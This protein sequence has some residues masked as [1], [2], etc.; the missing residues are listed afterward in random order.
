MFPHRS[1]P[2]IDRRT[3]KIDR[4]WN[5]PRKLLNYYKINSKSTSDTFRDTQYQWQIQDFPF[6]GMLTRLWLPTWALFGKK[7][8]RKWKNWVPLGVV[9]APAGS[10]NACDIVTKMNTKGNLISQLN[11]FHYYQMIILSKI[12]ISSQKWH[13]I[14]R[15]INKNK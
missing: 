5:K 3:T 15:K 13:Q 4:I 10:A 1:E 7:C 9:A 6:G 12:L 2:I 14:C 11:K 8:L